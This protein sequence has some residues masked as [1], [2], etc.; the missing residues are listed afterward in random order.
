MSGLD[1]VVHRREQ[2]GSHR[3]EV[4]RVPE[5]GRERG[6]RLVRVVADPV[7]P[8]VHDLLHPPPQRAEQ[9]RRGQ[10]RPFGSRF[11]MS[12]SRAP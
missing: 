5:P 1:G 4:H 2:V 7:E 3:V 9:R 6:H 11:D 10:A 12:P 8:L